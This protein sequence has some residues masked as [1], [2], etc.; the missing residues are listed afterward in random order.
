MTNL[1]Q[2]GETGE[3]SICAGL[4]KYRAE[5]SKIS[6]MTFDQL[7][8]LKAVTR[9]SDQRTTDTGSLEDGASIGSGDVVGAQMDAVRSTGNCNVDSGID[10]QI[11]R[12]ARSSRVRVAHNRCRLLSQIQQL[13]RIQISLA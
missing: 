2:A 11:S 3:P 10:Q 7:H 5:D 4:V 6:S 13:A 9:Y 8:G 1:L 12:I